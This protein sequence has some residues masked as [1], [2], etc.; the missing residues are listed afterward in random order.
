METCILF[1]QRDPY[2]AVPMGGFP[3]SQVPVGLRHIEHHY[4]YCVISTWRATDYTQGVE[5][6]MAVK[7]QPALMI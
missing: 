3:L 5:A 6:I 1:K 7:C 4:R 2:S